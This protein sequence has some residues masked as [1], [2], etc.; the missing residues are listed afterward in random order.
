AQRLFHFV[1]RELA[2]VPV[3]VPM[4]GLRPAEP[5]A[6]LAAGAGDVKDKA[7]LLGAM[8]AAAG[9]EA[10]PVFLNRDRLPLAE[11]VP[12]MEQFDALVLRLELPDGVP[13]YLDPAG[14]SDTFGWCAAAAD[15]RGLFVGRD[16]T[17]FA[18]TGA[19]TGPANAAEN[20]MT[21]RLDADGG[22]AIEVGAALSGLFAT[23]ARELLGR[24][25][26][27]E[28][29]A[30]LR[31]LASRWAAGAEPRGG[32]ATGLEASDCGVELRQAIARG[33]LTVRQGDVVVLDTPSLP[34]TFAEVSFWLGEPERRT[35]LDLGEPAVSRTVTEIHLPPGS[36]V[37]HLPAETA[38]RTP[39]W[40]A[41]RTFR[42]DAERGMIRVEEEVAV[43]Q[44]TLPPADYAETR[45]FFET[46][47]ARAAGLILYRLPMVEAPVPRS[48]R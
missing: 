44:R 8:L 7:A 26:P 14:S 37:L 16:R 45:R 23:R 25:P 41:R 17:E 28:R 13:V 46:F 48:G 43:T 36:E 34:L 2:L 38:R 31:E 30:A 3:A 32:D 24:L 27:A 9:L 29:E 5:D 40:S 1:T 19:A 11:D 4:A 18:D 35:P 39:A 15:T 42:L 12:A 21:I 33:D 22:A 10:V 20:R 6:A 47:T